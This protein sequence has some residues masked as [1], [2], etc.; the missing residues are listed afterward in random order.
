[1][2][3]YIIT[4]RCIKFQTKIEKKHLQVFINPDVKNG[5][6]YIQIAIV[7]S[8]CNMI[9]R[10]EKENVEKYNPLTKKIHPA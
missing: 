8:N 6:K 5:R 2:I 10:I 1:L 4:S 7:T 3:K 9:P